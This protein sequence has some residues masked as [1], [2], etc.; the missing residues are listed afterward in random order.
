MSGYI[1]RTRKGWALSYRKG[2][3]DDETIFHL[4]THRIV[5]GEY[6]TLREPDGRQLPYRIASMSS[7]QSPIEQA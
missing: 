5:P 6:I 3:E 1:I 2:E 4:E 7:F